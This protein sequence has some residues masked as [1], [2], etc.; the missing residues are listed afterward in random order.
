MDLVPK[1]QESFDACIMWS[2]T[3]STGLCKW[4]HVTRTC[5]STDF[6][7]REIALHAMD[8]V[9]EMSLI[10]Q[11]TLHHNAPRCAAGGCPQDALF[12]LV[13]G[14]ARDETNP[15]GSMAFLIITMFGWQYSM[16]M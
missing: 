13:L 14:C 7:G 3:A 4:H 11:R 16:L 2:R 15:F 8:P 9:K 5:S 1:L 10:P 6:C 12:W